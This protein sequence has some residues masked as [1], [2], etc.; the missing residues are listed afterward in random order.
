MKNLKE[1]KRVSIAID[2]PSGAGK[3]SMARKIAEKLGFLY[4]D[5]GAIYR[6][7]AL[8]VLNSGVD[9]ADGAAVTALLPEIQVKPVY[10][11][12]GVQHMYLNQKDVTDEIR[13][14]EVSMAASRVAAYPGVRVFLLA[15]KNGERI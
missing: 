14:P 1:N 3:T 4:V 13:T 15:K 5:T 2:G 11:A 12:D 6:T 9:P 10:E 8:R 7:V